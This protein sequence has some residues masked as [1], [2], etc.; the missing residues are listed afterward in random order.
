LVKR[1]GTVVI[2]GAE[3]GGPLMDGFQRQLRAAVVSPFVSQRLTFVVSSEAASELAQVV[4]LA[5][6]GG[7]EPVVERTYP[8]V[9]AAAAIDHVTDGRA[10][11]KVVVRVRD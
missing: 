2:V 1:R 9:D 6:D 5:E 8:L 10:R 11:G 4:A 3:T 7:F